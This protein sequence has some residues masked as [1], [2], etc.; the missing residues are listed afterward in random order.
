MTNKIIFQNNYYFAF[1]VEIICKYII[2]IKD[3]QKRIERK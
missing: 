1:I 3:K 2:K